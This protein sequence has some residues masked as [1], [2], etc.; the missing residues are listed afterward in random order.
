M[1]D[2]EDDE[3][4]ATVVDDFLL[5]RLSSAEQS[6]ASEEGIHTFY[7]EL[8]DNITP[9]AAPRPSLSLPQSSHVAGRTASTL[10]PYSVTQIP[11]R[12]QSISL[13]PRQLLALDTDVGQP[14]NMHPS[15]SARER[16]LKPWIEP[17]DSFGE[18]EMTLRM[19]L[20]RK[21]LRADESQIY[22]ENGVGSWDVADQVTA[23]RNNDRWR[24][25]H[26]RR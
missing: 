19:T 8:P 13:K 22:P 14:E 4:G 16:P 25:W 3:D 12:S 26:R 24:F 11:H 5:P 17:A 10:P 15:M 23:H 21:D 7:A 2:E 1:D 18:R 20:T 6:T 9:P